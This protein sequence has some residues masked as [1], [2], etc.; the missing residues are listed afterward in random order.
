MRGKVKTGIELKTPRSDTMLNYRL[1]QKFKLLGY[2]KFNHL[3][4][5][6]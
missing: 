1:F 2:G 3:P 6:F 4:T 5:Q